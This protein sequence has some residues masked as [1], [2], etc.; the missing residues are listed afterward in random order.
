MQ[1]LPP[2]DACIQETITAYREA[3]AL[4]GY[5]GPNREADEIIDFLGVSTD[6]QR[7]GRLAAF[8]P[9]SMIAAVDRAACLARLYPE[10]LIDEASLALLD[11]LVARVRS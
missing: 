9:E 6:G 4:L 7:G 8:Y 11:L 2:A 10:A 1:N 5:S 3:C